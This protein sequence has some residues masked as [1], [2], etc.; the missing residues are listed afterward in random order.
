MS[1]VPDTFRTRVAALAETHTASGYKFARM[2]G[3]QWGIL[4]TLASHHGWSNG[5][6]WSWSGPRTTERLLD[7][8][9][10]RGLAVREEVSLDGHRTHVRYTAD[11]TVQ[12]VWDEMKAEQDAANAARWAQ[13]DAERQAAEQKARAEREATATLIANHWAEY[14]GLVADF[15]LYHQSK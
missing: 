15:L 9:V 2:S 14:E 5:G 11:P 10:K 7:S 6:G 1:A 4:R 13:K 8:L 3:D 12:A